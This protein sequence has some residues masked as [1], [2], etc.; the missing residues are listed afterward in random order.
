[1]INRLT[2]MHSG[3]TDVIAPDQLVLSVHIHMVLLAVMAL[4]A[5]ARRE[6]SPPDC[7]LILI[8]TARILIFLAPLGGLVSPVLGHF[9]LLC[10]FRGIRPP[11]PGHPPTC[12]T[13]P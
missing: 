10:V 9:A 8:S 4:A 13:L 2:V 6:N 5:L 7:F 3:V 12:D 1:M 11:I